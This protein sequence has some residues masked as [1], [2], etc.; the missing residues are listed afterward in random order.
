MIPMTDLDPEAERRRIIKQRNIAVALLL[1]GM[2]LLFYF[3][4]IAR[5][6]S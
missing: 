6:G 2:V 1:V 3:V 4:T 5:L